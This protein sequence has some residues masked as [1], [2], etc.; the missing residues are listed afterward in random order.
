M[1][2]ATEF[3]KV[4]QEQVLDGIKQGQKAV[5]DAVGA[6]AKSIESIVPATP[7][8]PGLPLAEGIPTPAQIVAETFAFAEKLIAS[9]RDF[10]L[11]VL[12]AAAP[13]VPVKDAAKKS[14]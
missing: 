1:P 8:I 4:T 5:V 12:A 7:S 6:W 10:A 2:T 14:A 9:Q 3:S 13:A 11:Q